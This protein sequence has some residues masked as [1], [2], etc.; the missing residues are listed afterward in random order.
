MKSFVYTICDPLGI[1][2]RPA[3]LLAKIAKGFEGTAITVEKDG[4]AVPA[5]RLIR[6][7]GLGVGRGDRVTV[8]A[9]GM[10]E[11]KAIDAL[12][13]FFRENL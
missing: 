11:E 1:H 9:D 4:N 13:R 12:E 5:D 7:M 8:T 10:H 3:G 6:L 2:A